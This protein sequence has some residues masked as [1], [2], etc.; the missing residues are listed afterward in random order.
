M[1]YFPSLLFLAD[2]LWS[3]NRHVSEE[4]QEVARPESFSEGAAAA[5][6]SDKRI[7]A[8]LH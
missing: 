8:A 7:S 4:I 2:A 6:I 5:L 1:M 3:I